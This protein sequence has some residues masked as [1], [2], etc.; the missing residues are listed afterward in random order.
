M[1]ARIIDGKSLAK[2]KRALIKA[3]I[4]GKNIFPHLAIILANENPASEIYVARKIEA[5]KEVGIACNLYRLPS[6]STENDIITMIEALN[7]DV[8]IHGIFLQLPVG[9]HLDSLKIIQSID[10]AKDV[11]GLTYRNMGRVMAG[12]PYLAP[13]TPFGVMQLLNHEK[14]DLSGKHAVIIGRSLLFGKPM[15]QMLLQADCTVTQCHSKTVNLP[16]IV[17][18]ADIVIA[19]VGQHE[20]VK[21]EWVK[22][23]AVVIDVGINRK[24]DGKLVGDVNFKEVSQ[25]ASAITPVPGGVG[26]MTVACLLQ[27]TVIAAAA[28]INLKNR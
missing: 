6:D 3:E 28:A 15:G 1:A 19:A 2:E 12:Q 16:N 22:E 5:C 20:M 23:G 8:G 4:V 9:D 10:P 17:S 13:C 14:I 24:D 18:Q 25:K 27:N 21:G 26:P 7:K 11:D